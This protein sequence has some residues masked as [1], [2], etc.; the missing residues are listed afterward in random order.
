[1]ATKTR[2]LY[3]VAFACAC[4]IAWTALVFTEHL[5]AANALVL[6]AL[7]VSRAMSWRRERTKRRQYWSNKKSSSVGS[8]LSRLDS[9]LPEQTNFC[10]AVRRTIARAAGVPEKLIGASDAIA[11]YIDLGYEDPGVK[12]VKKVLKEE[13]GRR[14]NARFLWLHEPPADGTLAD[15]L[16]FC[17]RNW[18]KI[19]V[20]PSSQPPPA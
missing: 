19:I 18:Q 9:C 4:M 14:A 12:T 6:A 3:F 8:F 11:D 1:M 17:L 15:F 10:L 5:V 2:W 13:F 7:V 20:K 16:N